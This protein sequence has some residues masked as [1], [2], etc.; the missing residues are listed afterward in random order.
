MP[1]PIRWR[2]AAVSAVCALVRT[3]DTTGSRIDTSSTMIP[4]T[5]SISTRV[6][7]FWILDCRF[8]IEPFVID[9]MTTSLSP[10]PKSKISLLLAPRAADALDQA[11][12]GHEQGDDD[13]ADDD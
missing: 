4:I 8:W 9:R 13:E 1:A 10:T 2:N 5:V 6:N 7:P 3:A 11:D 12:H